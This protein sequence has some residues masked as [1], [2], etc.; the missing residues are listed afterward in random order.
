MRALGNYTANRIR[1]FAGIH[2]VQNDFANG[3]LPFK[4]F[5]AGLEVKRLG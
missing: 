1:K 2:T 3:K 4:R 5:A